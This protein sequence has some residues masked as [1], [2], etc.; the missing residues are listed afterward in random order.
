MFV[1]VIILEHDKSRGQIPVNEFK[2]VWDTAKASSR[3]TRFVNKGRC[4]E[5]YTKQ[6]GEIGKTVHVPYITALID[7]IVKDQSME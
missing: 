7:Y 3:E 4:L 5:A 2:G 1:R 6:D